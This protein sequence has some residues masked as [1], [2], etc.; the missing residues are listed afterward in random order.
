MEYYHAADSLAIGIAGDEKFRFALN[1]SNGDLRFD[2]G[3]GQQAQIAAM[4]G[5]G[6]T[7]NLG[8]SGGAAIRFMDTSGSHTR[9]LEV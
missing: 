9:E 3:S 7:Y 4:S 2:I 5:N 1:G 6:N 8:S